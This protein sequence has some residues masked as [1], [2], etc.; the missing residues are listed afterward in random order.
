M[1]TGR[2]I[3]PKGSTDKTFS[4]QLLHCG[5]DMVIITPLHGI[6]LHGHLLISLSGRILQE[7]E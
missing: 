4:A 3:A 1:V 6:Y 5:C 7:G 2:E